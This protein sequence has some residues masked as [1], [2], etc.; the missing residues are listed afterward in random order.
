MSKVLVGMS[1]GVDSSA[2]AHLLKEQGYDVEGLSFI[3]WEARQRNDFT[4]CCSSQGIEDASRTA[5]QIGIPHNSVDVRDEFI[6][7]VIEPF[8]DAY[9]KGRTP[10]P[11]ILCNRYIKFPFLLKEAEKKGAEFIATGHYARIERASGI[12]DLGLGI[13]KKLNPNGQQL[14]PAF[15]NPQPPTPNPTPFLKKGADP[16]KDQSYFLYV[17]RQEE[18]NRLLL[19]LGDYKKEDVRN[20]ANKLGLPSAKRPESQEICFIEDKNYFKFI[21]KINPLAGAAGPIM[22]MD[23]KVLGEH[24]GIYNYTIGQRK[25]LGISSP[26]PLYVSKIDAVKNIVYVGPQESAKIKE[27]DVSDLNWL[28][29]VHPFTQSLSSASRPGRPIHQ[30][31]VKVRSMM[32]AEPATIS[33]SPDSGTV[34]VIFDDPQWAPAPGQSAVFYDED[35][36]IGG[37]III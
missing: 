8:V 30:F 22:G 20:L 14:T 29:P 31:T 6:E 26:S 17:L 19:P 7:K 10:N 3:L 28:V 33:G 4:T 37:G 2:T 18:L 9:T 23:G 32:K 11:C 5:S 16:K 25:G 13:S 36:V 1:G 21:N 27:F 34:K 24:K 35:I 15:S 12:R